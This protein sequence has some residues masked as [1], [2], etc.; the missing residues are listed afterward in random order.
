MNQTVKKDCFILE[1]SVSPGGWRWAEMH[2]YTKK[3]NIFSILNLYLNGEMCIPS[4]GYGVWLY[5]Y[6]IENGTIIEYIDLHDYLQ[7]KF[8]G[9]SLEKTNS[10]AF[11]DIME[12]LGDFDDSELPEHEILFDWDA[13]K[14]RLHAF[15][16]TNPLKIEE[17]ITKE[18][19]SNLK[20]P[21]S[22]ISIMST[23][24]IGSLE[25]EIGE[26]F[27]PECDLIEES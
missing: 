9:Y 7:V 5:L 16:C 13:L 23:F 4:L 24:E 17:E 21:N 19:K 26:S 8:S 3:E 2:T 20:L 22:Y 12:E 25:A 15:S 18:I 6:V 1:M 10:Q 11:Y 14:Q 27:A